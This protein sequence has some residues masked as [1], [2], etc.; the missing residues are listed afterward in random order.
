MNRRAFLATSAAWVASFG[1][2]EVAVAQFAPGRPMRLIIPLAPG[3]ATDVYGRLVAEHMARTL[4]RP[5]IV[6]HKPGGS[7][8]VGHQHVV[9]QPADGNLLLLSTQAML[10]ILPNAQ[11]DLKWSLGDFIP[12]I[13]GVMSPLVLVAHPGVPARTFPELLAWIRQNPGKLTYSSYLAGTPSHFL[14]FQLNERFGL[15]LVHV[16]SK[17][18]GFQQTDLIAGHVLFGFAQMQ[19]SL[20]FVREGKLRAIATT[21]DPRSRHM[22]D[23][24]TFA[25]LGYPEFTA[26]VWFGLLLRAGTPPDVVAKVLDAAKAAHTDP[27]V[28]ARLDAQ[29][30]DTSGQTGPELAADIREQSDRWA[31]IIKASGYKAD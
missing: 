5:I 4:A 27:E 25:E 21:D 3:G 30:F 7:G 8:L 15:D 13:R 26:R 9:D 16:P 17:G 1:S 28:R 18:S 20:P 14:G 11:R 24:P 23:V 6:E 22:P 12:L 2:T 19:S 31:R 10:E 29:G